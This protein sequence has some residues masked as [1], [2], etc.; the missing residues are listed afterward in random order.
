MRELRPFQL[1]FILHRRR[2]T[3][4]AKEWLQ[5][6]WDLTISKAL[7]STQQ[8]NC[9][10]FNWKILIKSP[11]WINLL[12]SAA[13]HNSP[14]TAYK[15]FGDNVYCYCN[16]VIMFKISIYIAVQGHKT[17]EGKCR[18]EVDVGSIG[19]PGMWVAWFIF[20]QWAWMACPKK[21]I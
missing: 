11:L 2:A 14:F 18:E 16:N 19:F 20:L 21:T 17:P 10:L 5:L 1:L 15:C 8:N 12:W 4:H 9:D 3:Q 13:F 6:Q 7:I